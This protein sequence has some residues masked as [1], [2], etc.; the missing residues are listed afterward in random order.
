MNYDEL[1]HSNSGKNMGKQTSRESGDWLI[2]QLKRAISKNS[3]EN[4][5]DH[6]SE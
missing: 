1:K 2:K 3:K 4:E 5:Q 6:K